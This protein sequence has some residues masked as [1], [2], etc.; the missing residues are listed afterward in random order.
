MVGQGNFERKKKVRKILLA[1]E[2]EHLH[3]GDD[4]ESQLQNSWQYKLR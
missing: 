1:E 3:M 4:K 2:E